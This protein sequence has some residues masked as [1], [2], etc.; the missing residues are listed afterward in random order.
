M[1]KRASGMTYNLLSLLNTRLDP[2]NVSRRLIIIK[3]LNLML[4]QHRYVLLRG[5]FPLA[6]ALARDALCHLI[7]VFSIGSRA[8]D[9]GLQKVCQAGNTLWGQVASRAR[10]AAV[11]DKNA[12]QYRRYGY[13]ITR[14]L[15][16]IQNRA[17]RDGF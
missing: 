16:R 12:S 8:R 1:L 14:T 5:Q 11:R 6:K 13:Q 4:A 7:S 17:V 2:W 10:A 15:R 9:A 3:L